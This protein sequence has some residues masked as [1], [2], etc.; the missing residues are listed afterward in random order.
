MSSLLAGAILPGG[1]LPTLIGGAVLLAVG[2]TGGAY[3][4][5]KLDG[6]AL[7]KSQTQTAQAKADLA[8]YGARVAAASA[9]ASADAQARQDALQASLNTLQA[10]LAKTQKEADAKSAKLSA[11]L[12]NAKPGD[13]RP[14]G[15]AAA[16]YYDSLRNGSAPDTGPNP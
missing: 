16:S 4:T 15:P 2:A 11:L 7:A 3:V 9:K 5:H 6:T 8:A 12:A 1:I 10:Q 14:I 13:I